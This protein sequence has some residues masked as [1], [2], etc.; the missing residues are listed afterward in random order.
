MSRV[1]FRALTGT[2]SGAVMLPRMKLL[3]PLAQH[4]KEPFKALQ[5]RLDLGPF[6][7]F[8]GSTTGQLYAGIMAQ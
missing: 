6:D 1:Q 3:S 7:S 8:L 5:E 4:T 2:T